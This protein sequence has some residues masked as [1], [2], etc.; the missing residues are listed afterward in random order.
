MEIPLDGKVAET[1]LKAFVNTYKFDL[2]DYEILWP[3]L[4]GR[5]RK[6]IDSGNHSL[7]HVDRVG[8]MR[9]SGRSQAVKRL[10]LGDATVT[11]YSVQTWSSREIPHNFV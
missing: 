4:L 10:K 5:L 3:Y 8:S 7:I 6:E 2:S 9:E 11:T 1:L